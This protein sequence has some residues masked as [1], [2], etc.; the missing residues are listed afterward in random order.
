MFI[1]VRIKFS[2]DFNQKA[3][4][5]SIQGDDGIFFKLY[6]IRSLFQIS[7]NLVSVIIKI[8]N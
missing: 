1:Y 5:F 7:K 3:R 4:T 2:T 6:Y 8:N